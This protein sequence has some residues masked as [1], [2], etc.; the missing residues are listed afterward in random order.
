MSEQTVI[1][2]KYPLPDNCMVEQFRILLPHGSKVL[3][4]QMQNGKPYIWAQHEPGARKCERD[5]LVVSTGEQFEIETT[6]IG[7]LS[8]EVQMSRYVGTWQ[9]GPHVWHLYEIRS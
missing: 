7:P 9:D 5:F 1:I 3:T 6:R 8:R 2:F 4:V